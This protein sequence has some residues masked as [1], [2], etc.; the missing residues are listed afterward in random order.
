MFKLQVVHPT[1]EELDGRDVGHS[2][3]FTRIVIGAL[4]DVVCTVMEGAQFFSNFGID[5]A[6][7]EIV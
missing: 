2:T 1:L 7:V 6:E 3:I 4:C 5:V